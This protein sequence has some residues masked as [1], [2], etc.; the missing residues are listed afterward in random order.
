MINL[1]VDIAIIGGGPAGLAAAVSA[2]ETGAKNI[3]ILDRNSWVGGILTQCIHD[4]FGVE[5]TGISMTG[6][7]YADMYIK[8]AQKYKI[9]FLNDTMVL[10]IE[11]NKTIKAINGFSKNNNK[12]IKQGTKPPKKPCNVFLPTIFNFFFPFL[13]F[14]W[15]ARFQY[16]IQEIVYIPS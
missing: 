9:K 11:K 4:G 15:Y 14:D 1:N 10:Q 7:E 3:I 13:N 2:H 16:F 5:E 8:K 12:K 6:P